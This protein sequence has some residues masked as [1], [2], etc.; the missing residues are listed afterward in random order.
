VYNYYPY[1]PTY[2]PYYD[3]A[4]YNP[5][6]PSDSS[7]ADLNAP[8]SPYGEYNFN[9]NPNSG[10]SLGDSG[11]FLYGQ[12]PQFKAAPTGPPPAPQPKPDLVS[13]PPI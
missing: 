9:L 10:L 12:V 11:P 5:G 4:P 7:G 6:S 13:Q 8:S 1:Y 2:N 3:P